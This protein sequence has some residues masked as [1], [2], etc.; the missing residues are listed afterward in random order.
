MLRTL[1]LRSQFSYFM[2]VNLDNH[3][4][5]APSPSFSFLMCRF[6]LIF[7]TLRVQRGQI[8][9]GTREV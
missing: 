9:I 3:F 5:P 6:D 1:S 7:S 2:A 8:R 4:T